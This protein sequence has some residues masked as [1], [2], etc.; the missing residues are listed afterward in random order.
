MSTGVQPTGFVI[1]TLPQILADIEARNIVAFGPDVVQTPQSPLGQINGLL[2][3]LA[4]SIWELAQE[5]YQSHDPDQV[6]GVR[7]DNLAAIRGLAR[8]GL[9][10]DAAFAREITN[11]TISQIKPSDAVNAI[12]DVEGVSWVSVIEN[13]TSFTDPSGVPSHSLAFA[14]IGGDD[15]EVAQAIY[16]NTVPGIGLFGMTSTEISV[17]G[18]CRQINFIRPQDVPVMADITIRV[19][20]DPCNCGMTSPQEVVDYLD[21]VANGD[22]GLLNG[23]LVDQARI[24][25]MLGTIGG[26][27]VT[28]A[29][30]GRVG[31]E[32][33]E[34][35]VQASILERPVLV[36]KNISVRFA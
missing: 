36:A 4:H 15:G 11:R 20:G 1:K 22:C 35:G 14:V 28:R 31:E 6:E 27:S 19:I 7:L 18:Y 24:E 8:N 12:K 5:T 23:A 9:Q 16:E 29:V 34:T 13:S 21:A 33:S 3:D 10:T 30:A 25:A 26:V 2:A 17:G 32:M